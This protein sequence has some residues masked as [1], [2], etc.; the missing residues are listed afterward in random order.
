[1]KEYRATGMLL[2]TDED[3][4]KEVSLRKGGK[5]NLNA[6]GDVAKRLLKRGAIVP[7]VVETTQEV[8][9]AAGRGKSVARDEDSSHSQAAGSIGTLGE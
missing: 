7:H 4:G 5:I 3:L 9:K 8:V 6:N 2:A 1:M